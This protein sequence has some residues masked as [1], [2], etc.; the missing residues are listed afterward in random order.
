MVA[1]MRAS[2]AAAVRA[3]VLALIAGSAVNH[4]GHTAGLTVPNGRAQRE[5]IT[6]ALTAARTRPD[7]V[8]YLEAHGTG[9]PLGDPIEVRAAAEVFCADRD[10][11]TPCSSAR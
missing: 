2:D 1:L 3:P 8:D 9:T 10:P 5:L 6:A 4:D 7:E 11:A